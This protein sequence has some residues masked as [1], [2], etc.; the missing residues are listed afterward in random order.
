MRMIKKGR[1][2]GGG[3]S[4]RMTINTRTGLLI[5]NRMSFLKI[6]SLGQIDVRLS[7]AIMTVCSLRL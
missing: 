5:M 1:L 4:N 2:K 6:R 7:E 3:G